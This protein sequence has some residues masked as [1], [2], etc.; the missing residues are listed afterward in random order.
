MENEVL[1]V[2]FVVG[3]LGDKVWGDSDP[4][5]W[6]WWSDVWMPG[7]MWWRPAW[8]LLDYNSH[9]RRHCGSIMWVDLVKPMIPPLGMPTLYFNY[10]LYE[11]QMG[12]LLA[13]YIFLLIY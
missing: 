11:D 3:R 9:W 12:I 7:D 5:G 13:A 10:Q 2:Y 1:C 6:W 8:E 4:G